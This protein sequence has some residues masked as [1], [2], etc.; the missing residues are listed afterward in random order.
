MTR[1]RNTLGVGLVGLAGYSLVRRRPGVAALAV[2]GATAC[3]APD[4]TSPHGLVFSLADG[5]EPPDWAKLDA[6]ENF[7]LFYMARKLDASLADLAEA[8]RGVE[9][10]IVRG[11]S[12]DG[13]IIGPNNDNRVPAYSRPGRGEVTLAWRGCAYRMS[14]V[15]ELAHVL[16]FAMTDDEDSQH[17]HPIWPPLDSEW[18]AHLG[19]KY[20]VCALDARV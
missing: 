2:L 16:L 6:G 4:H 5:V 14:L 11:D 10:E 15:H 19:E 9:V 3:G 12:P 8:L 7:I 17:Q 13:A 18:R 20:L 1:W